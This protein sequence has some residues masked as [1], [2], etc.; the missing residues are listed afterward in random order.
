M[1]VIRTHI[2]GPAYDDLH[3]EL[4]TQAGLSQ[5]WRWRESSMNVAFTP[6]SSQPR[7][8]PLLLSNKCRRSI[9]LTWERLALRAQ[10]RDA[11]PSK[12]RRT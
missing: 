4:G 12:A 11:L 10:L 8:K 7:K 6:C 3:S 1:H 9:L 5:D 2:I